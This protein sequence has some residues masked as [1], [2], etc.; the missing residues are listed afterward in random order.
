MNSSASCQVTPYRGAARER[1]SASPSSSS[2]GALVTCRKRPSRSALNTR[3]AAPR[4]DSSAANQMLLS[5]S[6]RTH[7]L[8]RFVNGGE[9]VAFDLLLGGAR[10]KSRLHPL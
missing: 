10:R 7:H 4:P 3:R 6:A 2:I 5:T 8:S 1:A 9:G